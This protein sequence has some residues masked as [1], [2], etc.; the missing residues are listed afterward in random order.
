MN[1]NLNQHKAQELERTIHDLDGL[2]RELDARIKIE[3]KRARA[4]DPA[5]PSYPSFAVSARERVQRLRA[6]IAWFEAELGAARR[7]LEKTGKDRPSTVRPTPH[8]H[9]PKAR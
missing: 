7:D 3:E 2:A 5:Q 4:S 1:V 9:S 8:K 6:S